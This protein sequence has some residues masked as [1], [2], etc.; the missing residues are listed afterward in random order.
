MGNTSLFGIWPVVPTVQT[1]S[2]NNAGCPVAWR[3]SFHGQYALYAHLLGKITSLFAGTENFKSVDFNKFL[4]FCFSPFQSCLPVYHTFCW[5]SFV[6][7]LR[8]G[9]HVGLA[10]PSFCF[11]SSVVR[12]AGT[13][14]PYNRPV[15]SST[16]TTTIFNDIITVTLHHGLCA[17][18]ADY[19]MS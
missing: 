8:F 18:S 2:A 9:F 3:L 16:I 5:N 17:F 7:L 4:F 13:R 19:I 10:I 14:R 6:L 11:Y 12:L 15:N 1:L